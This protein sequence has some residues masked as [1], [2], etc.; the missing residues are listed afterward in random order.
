M[1]RNS[2]NRKSQAGG[3]FVQTLQEVEIRANAS[4]ILHHERNKEHRVRGRTGCIMS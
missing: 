2:L 4:F 3:K 1:D